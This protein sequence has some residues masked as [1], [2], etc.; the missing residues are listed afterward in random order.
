MPHSWALLIMY[1]WQCLTNHHESQT[2]STK[3]FNPSCHSLPNFE[4]LVYDVDTISIT[5]TIMVS[6][7][8]WLSQSHSFIKWVQ[9]LPIFILQ[10]NQC[11]VLYSLLQERETS[12]PQSSQIMV[13]YI[14]SI[15]YRLERVKMFLPWFSLSLCLL[16][17]EVPWWAWK[18][19]KLSSWGKEAGIFLSYGPF[20]FLK[21]SFCLFS[22][23]G[24][25]TL[26]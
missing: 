8:I 21:V 7:S 4:F 13:V 24:S 17:M 10:S 26:R 22:S 1:Q 19:K 2:N 6:I 11:H 15:T 18:K 3:T 23:Y 12:L 14:I 5:I 16:H 20:T 25:L 9:D